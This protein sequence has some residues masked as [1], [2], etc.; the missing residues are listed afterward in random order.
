MQIQIRR[1][2]RIFRAKKEFVYI[3]FN[4]GTHKANERVSFRFR[5]AFEFASVGICGSPDTK[6]FVAGN[7]LQSCGGKNPRALWFGHNRLRSFKWGSVIGWEERRARSLSLRQLPFFI[8]PLF[9]LTLAFYPRKKRLNA[10]TP[11]LQLKTDHLD[12]AQQILLHLSSWD[13][14]HKRT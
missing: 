8:L 10:M 5:P 1:R 13:P 6:S 3:F 2:A 7:C 14:P 11:A 4:S 12:L 9:E